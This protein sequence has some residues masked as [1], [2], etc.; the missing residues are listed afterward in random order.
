MRGVPQHGLGRP[1]QGGNQPLAQILLGVG[2]AGLGYY[3][4]TGYTERQ[5]FRQHLRDGLN[6]VGIGLVKAD[7]GRKATGEPVWYLTIQ[8]PTLGVHSLRAAL[9]LGV[10]PYSAD[11]LRNLLTRLRNWLLLNAA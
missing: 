1:R 4:W 6:E 2:L 8:H 10:D 9:P 7:V 5:E 11:S 3:L